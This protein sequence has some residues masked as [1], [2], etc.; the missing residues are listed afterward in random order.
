MA[1]E[2]EQELAARLA[3]Q[4]Q[5]ATLKRKDYLPAFLAAR[6]DVIEAMVAGFALKTIWEH[7]R[8]IGRIPFRYETFLK[9]VRRHITDV[10]ANIGRPSGRATIAGSTKRG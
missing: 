3:R 5:T 1:A 6:S 8:E 2:I 7:M 10:P 9:Y 4:Q